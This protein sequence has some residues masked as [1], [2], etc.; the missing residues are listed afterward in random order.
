[1]IE[2]VILPKGQSNIDLIIK[3][4]L[5]G[6]IYDICDENLLD[7][8]IFYE[9]YYTKSENKLLE[10]LSNPLSEL[11]NCNVNYSDFNELFSG[12]SSEYYYLFR[13][14]NIDGY[15]LTNGNNIRKTLL[16]DMPNNQT[17]L[18][19]YFKKY[20]L[21]K[22]RFEILASSNL[23]GLS[24]FYIQICSNYNK[25][26]LEYRNDYPIYISF[27][28]TIYLKDN[29]YRLISHE[30]STE[31]IF[32]NNYYGWIKTQAKTIID[33]GCEIVI[34]ESIISCVENVELYN[35]ETGL[36]RSIGTVF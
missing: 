5:N 33:N 6:S 7:F 17:D 26:L 29:R 24:S 2:N 27:P 23:V 11:N 30:Y 1:M 4:S 9:Y 34:P 35:Y 15:Y 16:V 12:I 14:K 25:K 20:D 36:I 10:M 18:T 19:L 21:N 28:G 3:E 13:V 32:G 8:L 31:S 22:I